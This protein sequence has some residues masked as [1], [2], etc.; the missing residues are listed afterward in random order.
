MG[1]IQLYKNMVIHCLKINLFVS[2]I[3]EIGLS[4][5]SEKEDWTIILRKF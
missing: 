5:Y 1:V 2:T 3:K 4:S